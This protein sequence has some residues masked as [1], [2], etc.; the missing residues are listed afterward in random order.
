M[1]CEK[2]PGNSVGDSNGVSGERGAL[3]KSLMRG[4]GKFSKSLLG[5][6]SKLVA[7]SSSSRVP[8]GGRSDSGVVNMENE[9][10]WPG[11]GD[12]DCCS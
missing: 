3:R 4:P 8:S 1:S 5:S 12:G 2:A 7:A 9:S 6:K 10:N 11:T